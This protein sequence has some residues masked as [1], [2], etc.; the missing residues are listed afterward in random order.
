M[1]HFVSSSYRDVANRVRSR[2]NVVSLSDLTGSQGKRLLH[3]LP[4]H[5]LI[6]LYRYTPRASYVHNF[7]GI[8]AKVHNFP[9][10]EKIVTLLAV[11]FIEGDFKRCVCQLLTYEEKC[12]FEC[13]RLARACLAKADNSSLVPLQCVVEERGN[14]VATHWIRQSEGYNS[15]R[16]VTVQRY[17][18]KSK[19]Q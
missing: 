17:A 7:F 8:W 14:L 15:V 19:M 5:E 12:S 1:S 4:Q 10:V 3:G 9:V 13:V 16:V 2:G 6:V 18:W 11:N